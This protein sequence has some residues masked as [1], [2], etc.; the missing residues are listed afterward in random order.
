[1]GTGKDEGTSPMIYQMPYEEA[2]NLLY[3][4]MGTPPREHQKAISVF[5]I[6]NPYKKNIPVPVQ[7]FKPNNLKKRPKT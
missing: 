2:A 7:E 1:M 6:Q 4:N 3:A 5:Q